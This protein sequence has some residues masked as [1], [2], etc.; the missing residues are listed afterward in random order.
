MKKNICLILWN[1][2]QEA[3]AEPA[4]IP[5][6]RFYKKDAPMGHKWTQCY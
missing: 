6:F 3:P 2:F 1:D 5:I 4:E